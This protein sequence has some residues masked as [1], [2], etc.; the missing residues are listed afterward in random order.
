MDKK[1]YPIEEKK[2]PP[3]HELEKIGV[4]Y[5]VHAYLRPMWFTIYLE[6]RMNLGGNVMCDIC[7]RS[8]AHNHVKVDNIYKI[9]PLVA[10][11]VNTY[12]WCA[13]CADFTWKDRQK[14]LRKRKGLDNFKNLQYLRHVLQYDK[15]DVIIGIIR[16]KRILRNHDREKST[17]RFKRIGN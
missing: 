10:N 4:R 16:L 15:E 3:R 7:R 11:K 5:L 13:Y 14:R 17:A 1:R 9:P 2:I 12:I 8:R 6:S